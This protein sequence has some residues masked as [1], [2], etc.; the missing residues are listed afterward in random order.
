ML[1]ILHMGNR[2]GLTYKGGQ[3]PIIHLQ[4]DMLA[5][6]R[7]A[8]S[9]HVLWAFTDRN[10]RD[11]RADYRKAILDLSRV[12]WIA[13][14]SDNFRDAVVKEGKQAEFLVK[15]RF[16]WN[17]VTTIGVIDDTVR[18]QVDGILVNAAHKPA[19][20]ITRGWYF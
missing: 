12:N 19:V 1:Y 9:S 3:R 8:D 15:D 4:A 2:P 18:Q 5:V 13:V 11:E 7:W 6:V 14:E 10:A 20:R 16:P 17:L